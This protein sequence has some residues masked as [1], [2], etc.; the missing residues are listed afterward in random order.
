MTKSLT[1]FL[2]TTIFL[3]LI[4]CSTGLAGISN[5]DS[6][7]DKK[8]AI[9]LLDDGKYDE[10][11]KLWRKYLN[12][13]KNQSDAEAWLYYGIALHANNELDA[14]KNA[15]KK[16]VNLNP[17]SD[18]AHSNY[19]TALYALGKV[20]EAH[21][22]M[23][24]ALDINDQ[25]AGA[26]YLR[27]IFNYQKGEYSNAY[28][29]A[30]RA[31]QLN[32]K[33]SSA[34]TLKAQSALVGY[35]RKDNSYEKPVNSWNNALSIFETG[36]ETYLKIARLSPET[37]FWRERLA[38]ITKYKTDPSSV[39]CLSTLPKEG[40]VA[41]IQILHKEK[42]IITDEARKKMIQGTIVLRTI[43]DSDGQVKNIIPL[44]YLDGG[45][46]NQAIKAA[47][48]IRFKPATENGKPICMALILEYSYGFN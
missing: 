38:T 33:L 20:K 35:Y 8:I 31:L 25:N 40:N 21:Q 26:I 29:D 36:I 5:S 7:D 15:L 43:F 32:P 4:L 24:L 42:L 13:S 44:S 16:A 22:E 6:D 19:A 14:A 48:A 17:K 10:S 39:S 11:V 47:Q 27:G 3:S 34:Y 41:Q 1:E 28:N 18:L 46:T 12:N 37:E 2:L 9:K 45:M 23:L 30:D